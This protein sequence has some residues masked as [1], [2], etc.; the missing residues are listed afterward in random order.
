MEFPESFFFKTNLQAILLNQI[1][2]KFDLP[3]H[4]EKAQIICY[5]EKQDRYINQNKH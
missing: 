4:C 5:N 1:K 2:K 3:F